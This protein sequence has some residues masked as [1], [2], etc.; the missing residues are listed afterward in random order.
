MADHWARIIP[1]PAT[2]AT[3]QTVEVGPPTDKVSGENPPLVGIVRLSYLLTAGQQ[4]P[5]DQV[6]AWVQVPDGSDQIG[7]IDLPAVLPVELPVKV[8]F[9]R[10]EGQR[11]TD[12]TL[13][14]CASLGGPILGEGQATESVL[15]GQGATAPVPLWAQRFT[16][17]PANAPLAAVTWQLLATGGGIVATGTSPTISAPIPRSARTIQLTAN[18]PGLVVWS[19]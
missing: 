19:Y 13:V 9:Q 18:A 6:Q 14:V 16:V 7:P 3:S 4:A 1:F 5:A 12:Q 15:L 2:M 10:A 8:S 17:Y 11:A